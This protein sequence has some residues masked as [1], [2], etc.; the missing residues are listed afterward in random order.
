MKN[1]SVRTVLITG[2]NGKTTIGHILK[3]IFRMHGVELIS[4][5]DREDSREE[6][7]GEFLDTIETA[8]ENGEQKIFAL[9][10]DEADFPFYTRFLKPDCCI[11]SNFSRNRLEKYGELHSMRAKICDALKDSPESILI[12]C[13]DDPLVASIAGKDA[14]M[15]KA[16][17]YG[18]ALDKAAPF[19]PA[20]LEQEKSG[21]TDVYYYREAPHCNFCGEKLEYDLLRFA[22]F[23]DYRCPACGFKRPEPDLNFC[24]L[25]KTPASSHCL[26][27]CNIASL[28]EAAPQLAADNE[29]KCSR[30]IDVEFAALHDLYNCSAAALCAILLGM[31]PDGVFEALSKCPPPRGRYERF[32]RE[33]IEICLLRAS[34]PEAFN[35]ILPEIFTAED[36]AALIITLDEEAGSVFDM[37]WMWDIMF[38]KMPIPEIFAFSGSLAPYTA[39]R[40]F[41]ADYPKDK[42]AISM[43][44]NEEA[45]LQKRSGEE[46]AFI[47]NERE[48]FEHILERC[49]SE[50]P[51]KTL[52]WLA[53][54]AASRRITSKSL[55]LKS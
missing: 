2:T 6:R 37:S 24:R 44:A 47:G 8:A 29:D 33:G 55:E 48:L 17:F 30:E 20:A 4:N 9:E 22:N 54:K 32:T 21:E 5:I 19:S 18:S 39:L 23:G 52:Y 53:N 26:F 41:Y 16:Y 11:I 28:K 14:G 34:N 35:S 42:T 51:G 3:R 10:V 40:A 46:F 1:N 45:F 15:Q 36:F 43:S 7:A 49:R 38:E 12:L 27:N 50:K 13:A 25:S 31:N